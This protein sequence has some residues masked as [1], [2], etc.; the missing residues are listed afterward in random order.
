M[1]A[2]KI[3]LFDVAGV[4]YPTN[5]AVGEAIQAKFGLSGEQIMPIFSQLHKDFSIGKITSDEYLEKVAKILGVD[6]AEVTEELFTDSFMLAMSPTP[7][8][9]E[10]LNKLALVQG[11]QLVILSDTTPIFNKVRKLSGVYEKFT[12]QFLSFEIG[13]LKPDPMAYNKVIDALK[14]RPEEIFFVDDRFINVE[15][16]RALGIH[17]EVFTS[18][19]Q[20]EEDL[21]EVGVLA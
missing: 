19:A 20:L 8:M 5:N 18:T 7:G 3:L 11:T 10:L 17:A 2:I 12:R 16:A 6:R 21:K 13:Y 1:V 4:L 9:S 14:V 15:A